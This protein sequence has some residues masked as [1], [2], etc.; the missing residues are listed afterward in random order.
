MFTAAQL[1]PG[2][3]AEFDPLVVEQRPRSI[4]R[5]GIRVDIHDSTLLARRT[6]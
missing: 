2:L 6:R 4:I 3:P 5:D 1:L